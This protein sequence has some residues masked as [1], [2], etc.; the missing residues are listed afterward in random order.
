MSED[1][2][3]EGCGVN[4]VWQCSEMNFALSLFKNACQGSAYFYTVSA[5]MGWAFIEFFAWS[6]HSV[7]V[8][9]L[10]VCIQ[11]PCWLGAAFL[12]CN[13]ICELINRRRDAL[14][15]FLILG[16]AFFSIIGMLTP[17]I[18]KS[19]ALV[20]FGSFPSISPLFQLT[21]FWLTIGMMIYVIVMSFEYLQ[22][23]SGILRIRLSLTMT[24]I[25]LFFVT[26]AFMNAVILLYGENKIIPSLGSSLTCIQSILV[27]TAIMRY[28]LLTF[29]I[30]QA[31]NDL[32][33]TSNDGIILFDQDGKVV[34]INK[35]ARAFF[36]ISPK[37]AFGLHITDIIPAPYDP[38][39][40]YRDLEIVSPTPLSTT[41]AL[42]T[43]H[44]VS[45]GD[46]VIGRLLI[47]RDISQK[48]QGDEEGGLLEEEISRSQE[49][50]MITIGQLAIGIVHDF[51]N[52][53][54]S[55]MSAAEVLSEES[56]PQEEKK[57]CIDIIRISS[58]HAAYMSRNLLNF[59]RKDKKILAPIDIS[60]IVGDTIAI[61]R[62]T[63]NQK[64]K[65]LYEKSATDTLIVG[66]AVML[67]NV[68]LNMG[69]NAD[70]AMPEGGTLTFVMRN[71]V[72]EG[73]S[74]DDSA[75]DFKSGAF[76]E[77]EIRDTGCGMTPELQQHIFE[78]FY[79][80]K[81]QGRGVGLG[82][83]AACGTIQ[84]HNGTI[85]VNSEIGAGTAFYLY[86]PLLK[87]QTTAKGEKE[88]VK[89]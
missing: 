39:V 21:F 82:L 23:V 12:F 7:S 29:G 63:I 88:E 13:F 47:I 77:I 24:G 44:P 62:R 86:L 18:Y 35:R 78:P 80:L 34:E 11:I 83:S 79:S 67:Q 48:L 25:I 50:K 22:Q 54:T 75:F 68:F 20:S 43:Q 16:A 56:L 89:A 15:W 66:D 31:A 38:S 37:R 4:L 32:F 76:L 19:V 69:I 9:T 65:I 28:R 60:Q 49:Q 36:G 53:L 14:F 72:L 52:C 70:H 45:Q 57:S 74:F 55:I 3:L 33:A 73:D 27:F 81:A 30:P 51:N 61:L 40:D 59:S 46:E 84:Q 8:A 64:I 5:F 85:K 26:G 1:G 58:S 10:L 17:L 2:R 6:I 41:T 42:L 71:I 87:K